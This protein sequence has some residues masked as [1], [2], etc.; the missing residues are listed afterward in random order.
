[1]GS[2]AWRRL[3]DGDI[4]SIDNEYKQYEQ[5]LALSPILNIKRICETLI[6]RLLNILI[7]VVMGGH[8]S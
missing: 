4:I 8:L 2:G 3:D 7:N 1:M 6:K 5:P